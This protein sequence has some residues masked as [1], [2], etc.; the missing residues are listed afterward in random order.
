MA[1]P[2][3]TVYAHQ[4]ERLDSLV[5]RALGHTADA[6][7]AVLEAN[8]GLCLVAEAL[9]HGQAVEIPIAAAEVSLAPLVQLW[10]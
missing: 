10:S 8:P 6:V 2:T 5:H 4:D 7:E 9:P 1:G 3:A